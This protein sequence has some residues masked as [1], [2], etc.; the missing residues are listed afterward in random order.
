M[1]LVSM[2]RRFGGLQSAN[3]LRDETSRNIREA[4]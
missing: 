1:D 3:A 2:L 4:E